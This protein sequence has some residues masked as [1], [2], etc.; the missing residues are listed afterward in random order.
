MQSSGK[1]SVLESIVGKD[2][3]PR[4]S[5]EHREIAQLIAARVHVSEIQATDAYATI[6]MEKH[7]SA[8]QTHPAS[9]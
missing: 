9:C 2:F 4:G 3:L 5:G 7:K 6:M 8:C 1:S